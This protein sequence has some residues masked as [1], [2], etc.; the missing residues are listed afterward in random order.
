MFGFWPGVCIKSDSSM[1]T[2]LLMSVQ[3]VPSSLTIY[4]P[5]IL[6]YNEYRLFNC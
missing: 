1:E 5:Q 4:C 6:P 2:K 3:C